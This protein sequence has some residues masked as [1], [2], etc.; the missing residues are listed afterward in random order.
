MYLFC[1]EHPDIRRVLETGDHHRRFSGKRPP[2]AV[3]EDDVFWRGHKK[4]SHDSKNP[5]IFLKFCRCCRNNDLQIPLHS[6]IIVFSFEKVKLQLYY[7]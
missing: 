5:K 1:P 3:A 4:A 6:T 7:N 2:R